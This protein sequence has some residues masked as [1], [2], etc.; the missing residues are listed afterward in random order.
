MFKKPI[1]IAVFASGTGS[2]ALN[3]IDNF[4]SHPSMGVKLI[5]TNNPKAPIIETAASRQVPS[6]VMNPDEVKTGNGLS[7]KLERYGIHNIVLA[8]YLKLIPGL[9]IQSFNGRIA[10]LHP[11]LLPKFGGPG[12]YGAKVHRAVKEAGETESG[13][14]I[15]EVSELYDDGPII[16]QYRTELMPWDDATEIE[17]KVR[18]LEMAHLPGAI[19]KWILKSEAAK[20]S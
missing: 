1:A 4:R 13:I 19:E 12:M 9:L 10:N 18:A 6:W 17:K 7:E 15:H 2:N 8:G 3:L 16:A 14:T 5:V 20:H 11:A